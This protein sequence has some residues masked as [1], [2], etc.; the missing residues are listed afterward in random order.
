MLAELLPRNHSHSNG[1]IRAHMTLN[2]ASSGSRQVFYVSHWFALNCAGPTGGVF[3]TSTWNFTVVRK[4]DDPQLSGI[5]R[6]SKWIRIRA[7]KL[8]MAVFLT[9]VTFMKSSNDFQLSSSLQKEVFCVATPKTSG[10]VNLRHYWSH[11]C[12]GCKKVCW[13]LSEMQ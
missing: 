7:L 13:T 11:T 5:W 6:L 2:C 1:H 12:P 3:C 4:C 9:G 10:S 8:E